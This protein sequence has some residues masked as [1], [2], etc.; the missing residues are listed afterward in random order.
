LNIASYLPGFPVF[1][2]AF[3]VTYL[4]KSVKRFPSNVSETM[5]HVGLLWDVCWP[6]ETGT[7]QKCKQNTM[8]KP[9]DKTRIVLK[10]MEPEIVVASLCRQ[11]DNLAMGLN[12]I[13]N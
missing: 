6:G 3:G 11:E 10:G 9:A 8:R 2:R 5:A 7:S 4:A 12:R 13:E 1:E